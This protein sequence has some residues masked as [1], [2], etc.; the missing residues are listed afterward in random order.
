MNRRTFEK[1]IAAGFA[2]LTGTG[3]R[4]AGPLSQ[5]PSATFANPPKWP[6]GAYRRV[7]V[8]THVP[9]TGIPGFR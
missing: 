3:A 2:G 5:A 4:G 9:G 8:D 7:L 6:Q 1:T